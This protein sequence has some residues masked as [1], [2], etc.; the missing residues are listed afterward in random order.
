M[1]DFNGTGDLTD[2]HWSN[3][4]AGVAGNKFF[5]EVTSGA[6]VPVTTG[7]SANVAAIPPN[8][9]WDTKIK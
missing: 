4:V 9:V 3:V 6:V 5:A 8:M 7:M 2:M 1:S